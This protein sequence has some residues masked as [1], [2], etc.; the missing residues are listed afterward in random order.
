MSDAERLLVSCCNVKRWDS[1]PSM[2]A[3]LVLVD[4]GSL[5]VRQKVSL[6][7]FCPEAEGITGLCIHANKFA[8]N[9]QM[10]GTSLIGIIDRDLAV[11][12][13]VQTSKVR[14]PH[15]IVSV[16]DCLYSIS[17]GSDSIIKLRV[18]QEEKRSNRLLP[19]EESIWWSYNL[20][21]TRSV[22]VNSL[23]RSREGAFYISA[24]GQTESTKNDQHA[25]GF[26]VNV[27]TRAR[28]LTG[29]YGPHSLMCAEDHLIFCEALSGAIRDR[30][31]TVV[32]VSQG[33]V[34][35]LAA[36]RERL[37]VGVSDRRDESVSQSQKNLGVD[38]ERSIGAEIVVY[39]W[40]SFDLR[41]AIEIARID[42]GGVV[43][44]I[45]DLLLY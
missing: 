5:S 23:C 14:R 43:H 11:S 3:G 29:L 10:S 12:A 2:D 40:Q 34:R 24:T 25:T 22:H 35:G 33:F 13:L 44:E 30:H 38:R 37:Y 45:F 36:S 17:S 21:G 20:I 27:A 1:Y 9:V 41:S 6:N 15:S 4:T 26:I 16:G 42:L 32:S 39:S 19:L 31:G 7:E 8:A 18:P 28:M